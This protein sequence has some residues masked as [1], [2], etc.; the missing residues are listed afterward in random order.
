MPLLEKSSHLNS[1]EH[2]NKTE[3]RR[4]WCEDCNRYISD[5]TRHFQSEIHLQNRQNRQQN[6]IQNTFGNGVEI[7]M[8]ENTYIKLKI[9]PTEN[10]EHR[11]NELLSENYFPRY[12]YNLSYLAKFS[13]II[14]GEEEVFKRW[15]KSDL[16]YNHT[17]QDTHNTLIQKLDDEQLEGSGFVF[18]E[19]EEVILEIYKVNDIQASSYIELPPKYKNSQSIINIK[20][21][22]QYCFLWCILAYLYPVEDNKNITSSYSKHFDKFNLEGLD[23][24]MKVKD[25]PKFE[26]LNRLSTGGQQYCIPKALCVN[27]FELTG[28]VLTPIHINT[29]YDQ[30]QIDLLLYQNHYCLITKLHC[31][32]NKDSHMKHVCRRCLTAFSSQPVLIDQI[33]RCQ[34]QQPTKITFSWKNQLKFEHYHMKVPVPIRVYADFE[35]IN[36]PGNDAK[37]LFKQI[38]IAVG[39]YV[40]SPFGNKYYSYFGTDCTK[41][42]VKEMLKF[43]LEANKFFKTNIELQITP[44]EE[45]SF[46]LAEEC[47]LCENPLEGEKVRDHDHLTGKYRGAAHN[48]CNIN[49][50]QRSSSFVPIFFHNFSGYDCHLLFEELLTEAYNQ[51]YNPTIIPKSLENYVSVQVG[52]LRFLDSYRFLSSSLNKLV[53]SLDNFPILK[54][55]GMSDDLFKKKLAYPYEYLNL[56]NFQELLNL[57]KEDYWSTLTQSYPSDDDIKR[58]QEFIDKNKIEN[59]REL[60]MLYLKRDV[61]Q[62][63]D[64]FENFVE[65]SAREYKINLL[66]S[67]SLP[68]YTWKAGLKLTNIKLV[69]IKCKEVLLLLENNIRGG[70]SSVMGNRHV[71][72][73]EHKQILYI[74]ANN[75]NGWAMSQYLPTG[76]FEKLQLPENYSQDQL[77]EDLIQIPDD[78]EYGYFIECDLEYPVEIKEKT[79]NFPFC[80]YQTKADPNVFS[81]YM[82]NINQPNYK[83][84]SKL[85]CDVTNKSKYMIHYR[86]FK[87]YLNQGMKVTKIHTIYRFKQSPWLGKYIDHN[88]QKRTVAK[89]NFEKDLY[90][91]MNNAFFGKTMENVRDKTNLEF[92][93]HC[94]I[95]QIIKRQS[96]LSFKGIVDH[97][98][99][100]SVYKFDN[101]KT[102]IDKPI[103]L[104]FT[105]LE[106][107]KLLL[108]EFYHNK[109]QPY[110]KQSIQLHYMDTDSFILSFDT[111]HQELINFL[112]ENKDEFDFSE[113]DKSHELYNPINKKVIGKMKIETSPVLVL[114]TFTAL[115]SKSYSFS[116]NNVQKAKQKG[117]QKAPKC[118]HYK[119]SLFNSETSSSTNISIRSN[120]H[121]LTVEKQNKLAL[122]PFDDKRLYIN[123]IQSLPWDKHTQKGDCPCIYCLKLIGLYYK[124]LTINRTD[125][126]IYWSV[127]YWKQALTHQQ[128]VKLIS[129]RA[130]VL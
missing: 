115:R 41:W 35:C 8:N 52:C 97:Y 129:D 66:Y 76:E 63:T 54:L 55:E 32:I 102:V 5:K 91:L 61:L 10:L 36:Q 2:K 112:Q 124:E 83:P 104:G 73:D 105:V 22:D 103:Y 94:Q 42:F 70:I 96:K 69:Y 123:P 3:Q 126:E 4:V 77:V 51:N 75:L 43:E 86:M 84:T 40:I 18:Q 49:C 107:S 24:P 65:S 17:Q 111:N 9:N 101:E 74:D 20:N 60:T 14:N 44:Q 1:D 19:I 116:Y 12:K 114:D 15:I 95:D 56:D 113:L 39:L 47:W 25:I 7:I 88:T 53:K 29:N 106:L 57:T 81:G 48:I 30:P 45:E 120:L 117:I 23:F 82:N 92:I 58:T 109:L 13:K 127:W 27:V 37:V 98:S 71:Q 100:F 62:L 119:N 64:V 125:E 46:Q 31:L 78:N 33:D 89:T 6:N 118:E 122:N 110:W 59:G 99:K 26:N 87:F 68:G 79:K 121:N 16:I 128:L 34:K 11:I 50:K 130:H 72:S 38:P 21:N 80:P 28:N 85:M 90:K 108:Y 93:D 67:Y